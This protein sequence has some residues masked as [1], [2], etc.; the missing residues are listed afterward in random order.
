MAQRKAPKKK[1][2]PR[3]VS[4]LKPGLS[5]AKNWANAHV[6][7]AS[8]SRK[9]MMRLI[10]TGIFVCLFILTGALWLGGFIPTLQASSARFTKH[11]LMNMGFVVTHVDVVGDGRISE[12]QVRDALG[13]QAGDYLFDMDIQ[14]AQARVQSLNWVD[15]AIVRR[16]WP[17]RVVVHINER[18]PYALWQEDGVFKLVDITGTHIRATELTEFSALPLVVGAGAAAHAPE[19]LD[20]LGGHPSLQAR[21]ASVIYIDQRR[22]DIVLKDT[23]VRVL[24][25]ADNPKQALAR[26]DK[27]QAENGVLDLELARIDM[28]VD[29]RLVLQPASTEIKKPKQGKRA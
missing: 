27:Y 17:N 5:G 20:I 15:T 28:R 6:R 25:P 1:P 10:G 19:F 21:V 3:R 2:A 12:Q 9:S 24:L 23:G 13:V 29:G 8:Y 18:I 11:R 22:W 7:A 16:L 14:N 26:L 4:P